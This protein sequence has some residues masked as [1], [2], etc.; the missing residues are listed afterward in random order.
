M[1]SAFKNF[2]ITFAICLL[3]FG[4]FGLKYGTD[5]LNSFKVAPDD[6]QTSV[7]E[8]SQSDA[9]VDVSAPEVSE[10]EENDNVLNPDGDIFTAVIMTVDDNNQ[11]VDMVFVDSNAQ[12]ERFVYCSIPVDKKV[13]NKIGSIDTIRNVF[14]TLSDDEIL[15]CVTAMTGIQTDYYM[16]LNRNSLIPISGKLPASIDFNTP[17]SFIPEGSETSIYIDSPD[18]RLLLKDMINGKMA[19]EWLFEYAPDGVIKNEYNVYYSAAAKALARYFFEREDISNDDNALSTIIGSASRTN[20]TV[21][22]ARKYAETIFAYDDFERTDL[23][24]S[25]SRE[26]DIKRI[27]EADGRYQ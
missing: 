13:P 21:D 20:L 25:G 18:G 16:V 5:F 26:I 4:F 7:V 11:P 27:R 14:A 12:T 6:E 24:Y 3:V 19:I 15:Q 9:S 8:E 2:F 22:T 23:V 17:I 1:A 10:P